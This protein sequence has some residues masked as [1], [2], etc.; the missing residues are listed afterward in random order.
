MIMRCNI[1]KVESRVKAV[2]RSRG[3]VRWSWTSP[4]LYVCTRLL[5]LLTPCSTYQTEMLGPLS[6][7]S[8]AEQRWKGGKRGCGRGSG[9]CMQMVPK[10]NYCYKSTSTAYNDSSTSG[11]AHAVVGSVEDRVVVLEELLA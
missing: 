7:C 6:T 10:Y 1:V 5:V 9:D 8:A 3:D 2:T 4:G 11:K